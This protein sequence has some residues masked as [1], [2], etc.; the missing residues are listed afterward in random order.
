MQASPSGLLNIYKPTDVQSFHIISQVRKKLGIRKAGY[1]GTLDNFAS[2]LLLVGV[3][4][5]TKLIKYLLEMDKEYKA[6]I[7][8]GKTSETLDR[9][10]TVIIVDENLRLDRKKV[11]EVLDSFVRTYD[12]MPPQYSSK[13]IG[14]RRASDLMREGKEVELRTVPITIHSMQML[15]FNP[16]GRIEITV[17]CSTGTYI[18][19]LAR[20]IAES[21]DTVAY[22]DALER[23]SNGPF[24]VEDSVEMGD[25]APEKHLISLREALPILPEG[26]LA[27]ASFSKLK[28][29]TP[30]SD[31]DFISPNLKKGAFKAIFNGQLVAVLQRTEDR[32]FRYLDNFQAGL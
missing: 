15:D 24:K 3:G 6:T 25:L 31:T 10:G 26:D 27:P 8:F 5:G 32:F 2:G 7:I 12:Q 14:G 18:R 23:R 30:L 29:G 17:R 9:K 22:L 28:N 13:K 21:L 11:E 4:Q 16:A 19:S 20:D 1:T